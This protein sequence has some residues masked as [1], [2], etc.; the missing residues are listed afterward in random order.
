LRPASGA[1]KATVPRLAAFCASTRPGA[2][3]NRNRTRE[4][5]VRR[6]APLL[7][8]LALAACPRPTPELPAA[9]D[10]ATVG[11]PELGAIAPVDC[12]AMVEQRFPPI[13]VAGA[14]E[15]VERS[16]T[17]DPLVAAARTAS[18]ALADAASERCTARNRCE[19]DETSF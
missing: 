4:V 13:V 5:H 7:L 1:V 11:R 12:A 16:S 17:Y 15:R 10:C 2:V 19:L 18:Q 3:A 9:I 6:V 14:A 8:L